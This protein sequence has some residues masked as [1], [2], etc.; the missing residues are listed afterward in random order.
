MNRKRYRHWS[1]VW[2]LAFGCL[3]LQPV[4][5][6]APLGH[7]LQDD[8]IIVDQGFLLATLDRAFPRG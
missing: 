3:A 1:R 6:Q 4:S 5:A 7:R 8:R 2:A